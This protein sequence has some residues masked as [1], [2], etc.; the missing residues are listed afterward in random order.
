MSPLSNI[1]A[2][3][4]L[5]STSLL[6]GGAGGSALLLA[7]QGIAG[8]QVSSPL[9]RDFTASSAET[10]LPN[11]AAVFCEDSGGRYEIR[12]NGAGAYGFCIL[13]EGS[14][15]DAWEYF[16]QKHPQPVSPK[17]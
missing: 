7:P 13:P 2:A 5:T 3:I 10:Q 14:E 6:S 11:P 8:V 9:M 15:V 12:N 1:L 4:V 17:E 16:R